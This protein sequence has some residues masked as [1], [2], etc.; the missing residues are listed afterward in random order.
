MRILF[1]ATPDVAINK[2]GLYTQIT[3]S[4][5]Y[6]EKLGVEVDLYDI[7]QPLK[8]DYDL[9]HIFRA[10]ISLYDTVKRLKQKGMKIVVSPVFASTHNLLTLRAINLLN[11]FLK[12]FKVFTLHL[13]VKEIMELANIILPNTDEEVKALSYGFGIPKTKFEKIP[14][15]VDEK[16][17]FADPNEFKAKYGMENFILYTGW[18]GSARK[19]T[20]NLVRALEGINKK[21]VFIGKIIDEGNYTQKCLSLIKK[22]PNIEILQPLPHDSSLLS[23]AYA[24]CDTFILPSKFE[25]PGLSALEAALAGAK[26][27]ITK[28][29]GT[30]EYFG[31]MAEYVNPGSVKS[32]RDGIIRSSSKKEDKR[33]REYIRENFLWEKV[34]EKLYKTYLERLL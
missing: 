12:N 2:G 24:A 4:K 21:V 8:E 29:G 22:N 13:F 6:L 19:N 7:W 14:N 5:K 23:S 33:L 27:V 31:D 26:I 18:I 32:I 1:I 10:D 3:N 11:E 9:I 20:L 28:R 30:R 25:T 17:Y 34:V 15:G 16:F